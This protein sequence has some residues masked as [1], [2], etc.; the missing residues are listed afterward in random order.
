M[1]R[2]VGD[3]AD[4]RNFKILQACELCGREVQMGPHRYV[5]HM[6]ASI[7]LFLCDACFEMN[8]DG[9][10]PRHEKKLI[11]HFQAKS[12]PVPERNQKGLIPRPYS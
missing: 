2:T 8:W 9:F 3:P 11:A 1:V 7:K 5:G 6:I 12:I 4:M 10:N